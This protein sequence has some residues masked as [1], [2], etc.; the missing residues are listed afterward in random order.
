MAARE[1]RESLATAEGADH[2]VD[3]LRLSARNLLIAAAGCVALFVAILIGVYQTSAG[4]WLDNAALEGF[5]STVHTEQQKNALDSVAHLCDPG[6]FVLTTLVLMGIALLRR[7]PRRAAAVAVLLAGSEITTQTLK[8]LLAETRFD[9]TVVGFNH[10]VNPVVP[11]PAFPSGHSTAAMSIAFAALLV[12]PR[13][14]RPLTA[15][16]GVLFALAVP[17]SIIALGW[18]YPSDIVGGYLVATAWC[19]VTLAG[20]RMADA[21]WPEAGT[22]RA[23]ARVRV[24]TA[25]APTAAIAIAAALAAVVA[26]VEW[27]TGF[28]DAHTSAA[29]A[30]VLIIICA[31]TLVTAISLADQRAS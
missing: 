17:F 3:P 15:A 7:S 24:A 14:W 20:L 2:K 31:A 19:L 23:K 18:H 10:I 13:A 1:P 30:A 5:L 16:V 22:L 12:V 11:A 8:P 27:L 6:P 21:R 28:A 4:L 25:V 9:G 29:I 26:S